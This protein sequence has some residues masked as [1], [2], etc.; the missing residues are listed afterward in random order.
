MKMALGENA[1][2]ALTTLRENKMR[3]FLTVLGVVIGITALLSVV[4]I[5]MGVYND[6]NAFLSDFGTDTL[7]I[8][9]F[10]PGIHTSGRLSPEERARKPLTLEDAKAIEELCPDVKAVSVALIP[11]IVEGAPG[12]RPLMSARYLDKEVAGVDYH[13]I[14]PEDEEVF[15]SRAEEG[16][17]IT[18]AENLHRADVALIGP[19]LAKALYP[20][21]DPIGKPILVDGVS[22]Q[23]I[24]V[25]AARKGQLVKDQAA[26]KAILVPY[27]TYQKHRP[28]DDE[29]MIG[30]V[31]YSGRMPQAEDEIRGVL[32]RRRR[33]PY[34]KP[35]N[36]G[37]SSAKEIADQFRQITG[38]VALLISVVS[39]IGLLVGG[40][41]VM[42]IMLM[43]VTQRTREIGVRKAIGARRRDVI[44]QFLT[45]AVVLTGSG[46]VIGVL[47][48]LGISL[49][50][51]LFLP[52]LPSSVPLWAIAVAV[53]VS[54]SV[55]LFF[56]MYPAVKASRL[57][58]VEALRYE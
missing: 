15:N 29:N 10:D 20:D 45:E 13:G 43:S 52:R 46:G 8:F 18:E 2:M 48:G 30:A 31:A 44:W 33:V 25:L 1:Q 40:V 39:S 50:I 19:D 47:L 57:D 51:H 4:A 32:R 34:D 23:V 3:S 24:G 26:D 5:L 58:P 55:G 56:G 21:G 27:R 49:L 7:F 16:R 54:M 38:S 9:K 35:D 6:V 42:N 36:F 37:V 22:Y 53:T 12:G 28:M 41:G 11:K 14:L 17:F